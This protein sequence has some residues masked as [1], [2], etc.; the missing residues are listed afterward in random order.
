MFKIG[1][2]SKLTFVSIRMLRYYDEVNLLKPE[3]V[4]QFTG[5]RYYSAKQIKKLNQIVALR[6]M[7]FNVNDIKSVIEEKSLEKLEVLLKS[8][9][10]EIE[11]SISLEIEKINK[12]NS[13]INNLYKERVDMEYNV[14]IK[15]VPKYKVISLR[16]IIPNYH[17][18]GV[19]WER[20]CTYLEKAKLKTG[21]LG[22]AIYH[23]EGHKDSDVDVEIVMELLE[24]SK[25]EEPFV[26]KETETLDKVAS[27]LVTGSYNNIAPAFNYLAT[28]IEENQHEICGNARQIPIKGPWDEKDE[29]DYLTEILIPIK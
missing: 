22:F 18:E 2:F 26:I 7:G 29:K 25:V 4:D 28:W 10:E 15:S 3:M 19:L 13:T 24:G 16:D 1:D 23:D 12:I 27:I 6:D 11:N 5:Y 9:K 21:A 14:N 8:K 17:A 20:L